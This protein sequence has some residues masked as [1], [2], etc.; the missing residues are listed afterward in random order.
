MTIKVLYH[1][2]ITPPRSNYHKNAHAVLF[3]PICIRFLFFFIIFLIFSLRFTIII[4]FVGA[5][6]KYN[7]SVKKFQFRLEFPFSI[8]APQTQPPGKIWNK[9][10]TT[11]K[12]ERNLQASPHFD[13]I[14][15]S[16]TAV[17]TR[18]ATTCIHSAHNWTIILRYCYTILRQRIHII[19]ILC[20]LSAILNR[21]LC[22]K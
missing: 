17:G 16:D 7:K 18:F 6:A 14:I 8:A 21:Y 13:C 2:P 5:P 4:I 10:C 3:L 22:A 1:R 15:Y 9:N 19:V 20:I 11:Q 12:S